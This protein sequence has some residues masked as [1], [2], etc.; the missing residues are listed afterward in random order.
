MSNDYIDDINMW[1]AERY[2]LRTAKA[3]RLR[4]QMLLERE[5][6]SPWKGLRVA[7]VA[8]SEIRVTMEVLDPA[9]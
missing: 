6:A 4:L 2:T 8:R 9:V 7:D 3:G 1:L 5:Y